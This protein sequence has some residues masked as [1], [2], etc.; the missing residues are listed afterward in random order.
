MYIYHRYILLNYKHACTDTLPSYWFKESANSGKYEYVVIYLPDA[1]ICVWSGLL[2][3]Y[4]TS[5]LILMRNIC[6]KIVNQIDLFFMTSLTEFYWTKYK[7]KM[8]FPYI[9]GTRV[10]SSLCQRDVLTLNYPDSKVHEANIGLTWVLSVPD[11]PHLAPMNLTVWSIS[12][13]TAHCKVRFVFFK[14]KSLIRGCH[15]KW[16]SMAVEI[17][18]HLEGHRQTRSIGSTKSLNVSRLVLQ[19]SLPD[20]LKPSVKSI[21]KM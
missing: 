5:H 14:F 21:M 18:R 20:P 3:G 9:R 2:W 17:S 10:C 4:T 15:L 1:D 13:N 7:P 19:F 16:P 12:I 6:E 11:G 8:S